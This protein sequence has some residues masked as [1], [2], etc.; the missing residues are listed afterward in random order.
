LEK[1][2][3]EYYGSL[4]EVRVDEVADLAQMLVSHFG[5]QARMAVRVKHD[6]SSF[7]LQL[8]IEPEVS[9]TPPVKK[10]KP[11]S[12]HAL[13]ALQMLATADA[14]KPT[15]EANP[16]VVSRLQRDKLIVISLLPSPYKARAVQNI[17]HMTITDAG[18]KVL[19]ENQ[20]RLP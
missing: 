1:I 2:Q 8:S 19:H 11:L 12:V 16:G 10:P 14:P 4:G 18:R 5:P 20:S 6:G 9:V 3:G 17:S 15:Q 13:Q 7:Q